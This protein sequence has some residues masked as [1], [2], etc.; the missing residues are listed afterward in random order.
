MNKKSKL[1]KANASMITTIVLIVL[2]IAALSTATYAWFSSNNVVNITDVEF[3]AAS[4]SEGGEGDLIVSW[5]NQSTDEFNIGF[6]GTSGSTLSPMMPKTIPTLGTTFSDFT[7][8]FVTSTVATGTDVNG[9]PTYVYRKDGTDCTPYI[10]ANPNNTTQ[11]EFYLIDINTDY[12][13][14]LTMSYDISGALANQLH[15]AVFINDRLVGI[16]S[17]SNIYYGTITKG[18]NPLDAAYSNDLIIEDDTILGNIQK[19]SYVACR[20]AVWYDGV[21]TID[22]HQSGT[23]A[24]TDLKFFGAFVD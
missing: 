22:E 23:S 6:A 12:G 21:T 8:N 1:L 24:L 7:N 14:E 16:L 17:K 5:N 13:M 11:T 19:T 3:T 20:F 18:E 4:N 15:I 2:L 10:C 9:N